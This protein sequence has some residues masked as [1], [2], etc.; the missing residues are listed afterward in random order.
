[1]KRQILK[2]S[3]E[4]RI[5]NFSEVP[6]LPP[7]RSGWVRPLRTAIGMSLRQLASRMGVSIQNLQALESREP[8]GNV[9]IAG[10]RRIAESLDMDFTYAFLPREGSLDAMIRKQA[11]SK[12]REL[13][14]RAHQTMLLEGQAVREELK[15]TM[16]RKRT[17][18]LIQRIP[19]NLWD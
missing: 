17:E 3:L 5:R 8:E 19:R 9:T 16:I 7:L 18:E 6:E 10:L 15:E 2:D 4:V 12:A 14:E 13:V 1:M 11:E